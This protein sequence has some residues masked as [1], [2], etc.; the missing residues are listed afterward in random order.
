MRTLDPMIQ[1]VLLEIFQRSPTQYLTFYLHKKFMYT[2]FLMK[3]TPCVETHRREYRGNAINY[4]KNH[5]K[6]FCEDL[7]IINYEM[8]VALGN[9]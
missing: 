6:L 7:A 3:L 4:A 2:F 5:L 9:R 8:S 1:E